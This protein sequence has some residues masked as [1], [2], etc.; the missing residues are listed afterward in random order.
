MLHL[1][2]AYGFSEKHHWKSVDLHQVGCR[3]WI[4][5][6]N[7]S[8]SSKDLKPLGMI[9]QVGMSPK[10]QFIVLLISQFELQCFSALLISQLWKIK[11][12][13]L[14]QSQMEEIRRLMEEMI[15][16]ETS[17][18]YTFGITRSSQSEVSD[19]QSVDKIKYRRATKHPKAK[20]N[21]L[22]R[23]IL[24]SFPIQHQLGTLGYREYEDTWK[25]CKIVVIKLDPQA[26]SR[27]F[28]VYVSPVFAS[29]DARWIGRPTGWANEGGIEGRTSLSRPYHASSFLT[30]LRIV[31]R[32]YDLRCM[33]CIHCKE[34]N[35]HLPLIHPSWIKYAN[36]R[37]LLINPSA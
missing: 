26:W 1:Q 6:I 5:D 32:I 4:K 7:A 31:A 35:V 13:R 25:T 24:C 22:A 30:G 14:P 9:F 16:F 19:R 23:A 29:Q 34:S 21:S 28:V 10:C 3:L 8:R 37:K 12:M 33:I 27:S 2:L 17:R 15:Q 18:V 11:P 36:S 20:Q